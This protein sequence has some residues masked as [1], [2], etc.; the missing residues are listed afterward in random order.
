MFPALLGSQSRLSL[1]NVK[2]DVYVNG[3]STQT[4]RESLGEQ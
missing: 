1:F 2:I 3:K 4:Q